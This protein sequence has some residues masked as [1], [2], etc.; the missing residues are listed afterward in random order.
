ME[1]SLPHTLRPLR[2]HGYALQLHQCTRSLSTPDEW[3]LPKV[4]GQICRGLSRWHSNLLQKPGR[5]RQACTVGVCETT[6]AWLI[7]QARKVWIRQVFSGVPWLRDFSR[8]CFHGQVEGQNHPVLGYSILGQG[9][10]T[11]LGVCQ[12]LSLVYQRLFQDHNTANA[13]LSPLLDPLEGLS[14][15]NCGKLGLEG[16]TRLPALK[17]GRGAC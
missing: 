17:M 3:Y 11:L 13:P 7:R 16:R 2:V 10:S 4:H 6:R 9:R 8:W 5:P 15:L 14:R 1:D 12:F